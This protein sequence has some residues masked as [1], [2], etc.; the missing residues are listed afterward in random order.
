MNARLASAIAFASL[1]L[2]PLALAHDNATPWALEGVAG[3]LPSSASNNDTVSGVYYAD[4]AL[5]ASHVGADVLG[6]AT[7]R[8]L[9]AGR[10]TCDLEVLSDG[11]ATGSPLDEPEVDGNGD[12]GTGQA[13]LFNDGGLGGVC[14]THAG[15]YEVDSYNTPGCGYGPALAEDAV[16]SDV[17]L[18]TFCDYASPVHVDPSVLGMLL[19]CVAD[20]LAPPEP[21]EAAT[22]AAEVAVCWVDPACPVAPGFVCGWD[23]T[24]GIEATQSGW[25]SAGVPFTPVPAP[26]DDEDGA[27]SALV[28]TAVFVDS[29]DGDAAVSAPTVGVIHQ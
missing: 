22:C 13:T 12:A 24:G 4:P 10:G 28:L 1:A 23:G 25:G 20:H 19:D 27:A 26:C 8:T 3:H 2:S 14:H 21:V 16:A 7:S 11:T 5:L 18:M 15:Y 9:T 6:Q 17:W 29:V